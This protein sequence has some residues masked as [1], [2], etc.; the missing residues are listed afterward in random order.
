MPIPSRTSTEPTPG[1]A[2]AAPPG[3]LAPVA[4]CPWCEVRGTETFARRGPFRVDQCTSCG[5]GFVNPAPDDTLL[6]AHYPDT[7]YATEDP[8]SPAVQ[9]HLRWKRYDVRRLLP[10]VGGLAPGRWLDVGCGIGGALVAA[11]DAGFE[12]EGIEMSESAAAFGA[13]SFDLDIRA[14]TLEDFSIPDETFSVVSLF[15]VL[16]H[17]RDP[18]GTL[19][20]IERTLRPGGAIVIEC[21]A[22][23]SWSA[24]W[25]G[26]RWFHLETPRHLFHFPRRAVARRLEDFGFSAQVLSGYHPAHGSA[27][28]HGSW[29]PPRDGLPLWRKAVRRAA[30]LAARAVSPLA[31]TLESACGRG[32]VLRVV[33][34]KPLRS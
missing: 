9:Q 18:S 5:V 6:S 19:E 4:A 29:F 34:R 14:G 20:R 13:R 31:A 17:L 30:F 32:S 16:E 21:P 24:G 2:P 33:A 27:S 8:S 26:E 23:D 7:Y 25:F 3:F 22:F 28:F 15:H 1:L 11:R 10:H 12:V